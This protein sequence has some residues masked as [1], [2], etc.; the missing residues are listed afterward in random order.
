MTVYTL[1]DLLPKDVL[2]KYASSKVRVPPWAFKPDHWN[3]SF[4]RGL[5]EVSRSFANAR[6]WEVGVGTGVN[7]IALSD[8]VQNATWFFSDYNPNCT[9][10]ASKNL[11]SAGVSGS[12]YPL[13]GSL[14]LFQSEKGTEIP[15]VDI[16]FG[17]LPQVPLE[18]DLSCSDKVAHYYNP[19]LY[20]G[21]KRNVCGLGLNEALLASAKKVLTKNGRVILNLSGRAGLDNLYRM[22]SENSYSSRVLYETVV[23]QHS[24]T[25]LETLALIE[26]NS[27]K[28]EQFEFYADSEALDVLCAS[29][30]EARRLSGK[31]VYH[32]I[33]VMEGTLM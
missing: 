24:G 6:L 2:G 30:A 21:S 27:T 14:N 15:Q 19:T 12:Y 20:P 11:E 29:R 25:S 8:V 33:F 4:L 32:K 31:C 22:F 26:S 16:V 3:T 17:C 5:I 9:L 23:P 13:D 7:L 28:C 10:L 18:G 1:S